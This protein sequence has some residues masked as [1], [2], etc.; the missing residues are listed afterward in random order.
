[1]RKLLILGGTTEASALATALAG[2]SRFETLLSFA[3]STRAPRPPPV[4]FRVGGFGGSAGLAR[5]LR[6]HDFDLLIDA[7]HPF[8]ARM[9]L[10]ARDAAASVG[11]A[12]LGV[13]RPAWPEDGCTV[14]ADMASAVAALGDAPVRVLLTIGQ[15]DLAAFLVAP[16][17]HYVVRSVDPPAVESLP[18]DAVVISARGP[19]LEENERALLRELGVSVLVTKNSGG[20]ATQAKLAVARD[21]GVAVVMVARPSPPEGVQTVADVQ[22]ALLWLDRHAGTDRLV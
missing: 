6:D 22:S 7:T 12:M 11:V 9:K 4:P 20:S 13:I 5:F 1:M 17:H 10:N 2:D 3:G 18:P 21:L 16:W 15:K 8:A 14:V 19:F